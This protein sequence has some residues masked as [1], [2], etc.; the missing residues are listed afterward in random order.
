LKTTNFKS[1]FLEKFILAILLLSFFASIK[2]VVFNDGSYIAKYL[3]KYATV[4]LVSD[5]SVG[6]I[7]E[8]SLYEDVVKKEVDQNVAIDSEVNMTEISEAIFLTD[9]IIAILLLVSI[10]F[11]FKKNLLPVPYLIV[12]LGSI[13]MWYLSNAIAVSLLG[14]KAFSEITLFAHATRWGL[15]I[16]LIWVMLFQNVEKPLHTRKIHL[17]IALC[18][19]AT[20]MAHGW[21]AFFLNPP[22]QDLIFNFFNLIGIS[23]ATPFV[24][25]LLKSIGCMDIIL[26]SIVLFIKSTKLYF[27][28]VCWGFITAMS[29]TVSLGLDFWDETL[30]RAPN[31]AMPLILLIIFFSYFKSDEHHV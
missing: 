27:W 30:K 15:P 9:K 5:E 19:S 18:C 29:R 25:M 23:A 31:F 2:P 22:F 12:C 17:F 11:L 4:S 16:V 8:N 28:M 24:L 7:M 1:G 3:V 20:F 6:A 10:C 13:S 14:G 21:E 26:A